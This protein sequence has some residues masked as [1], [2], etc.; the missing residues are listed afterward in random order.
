MLD[1]VVSAGDGFTAL[2]HVTARQSDTLRWT[3]DQILSMVV[4]RV[5][6]NDKIAAYLQVSKQ[7]LD[8]SATYRSACFYKVFPQTVYKGP[9]QSPTLRW[10]C[11]RCA[12][13]RGVVTPR[14]VLDLL[15]R[16]KQ[17]Q[18]DECAANPDGSSDWIIGSP[19]LQYGF[20]ELSK[21]KRQTYLEAEFPHLWVHIEKFIG[22]KTAYSESSLRSLLGRHWKEIAEDLASIGLF[23][24]TQ[25]N[26]EGLYSI[27]FLYRDG[28]ELTRG[29]A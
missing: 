28:L 19:A 22:G 24:K 5:F 27:P 2:T 3:E 15:I 16:A 9:K 8:A 23:S 1:Q 20:E 10:I 11:N 12:D 18:Y 4:K 13:G 6:A 17:R 29:K 26:N 14:D 7:Q 25:K 21:R